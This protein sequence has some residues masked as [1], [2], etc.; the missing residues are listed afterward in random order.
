MKE[1]QKRREC[2]DQLHKKQGGF[3]KLID[4][5][6]DYTFTYEEIAG[7]F[8]F[9]P[10]GGKVRICQLIRSL[11][12]PKRPHLDKEK[13]RANFDE[14]YKKQGGLAILLTL[15][16][17]QASDQE[18]TEQL[19]IEKERVKR[20]VFLLGLHHRNFNFRRKLTSREN[21]DKLYKDQGGV[22]ELE[23]MA[24]DPL[25]SLRNIAQHFGYKSPSGVYLALKR[26]GI[27]YISQESKDLEVRRRHFKERYGEGALERLEHML[28]CGWDLKEIACQF[29]LTLPGMKNVIKNLNLGR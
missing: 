10:R 7:Q 15:L 23:R 6:N 18:I 13:R 11:D 3:E 26:L 9:S 21:F 4:L 27:A 29:D 14:I 28:S 16:E 19:G 24:S 12:L 25:V 2:F 20:V 17:R 1:I 8:G 22:Q 5:L